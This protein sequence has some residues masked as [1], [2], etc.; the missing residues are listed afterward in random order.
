MNITIRSEDFTLT[1]E[2]T[3]YIHQKLSKL[4]YPAPFNAI[5]TNTLTFTLVES[6]GQ[7]HNKYTCRAEFTM[8]NSNIV[9]EEASLNMYAS[10][11]I[12]IARLKTLL[13]LHAA[14]AAPAPTGS[15]KLRRWLSEQ[16]GVS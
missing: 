6:L 2:L 4:Q 3:A 9:V 11:D 8:N 12:V 7:K 14:S 13:T 16:R 10:I 5:T 1:P 15:S